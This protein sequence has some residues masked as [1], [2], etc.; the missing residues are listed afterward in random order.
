M[1][2]GYNSY[3]GSTRSLVKFYLLSLPS[4]SNIMSANVNAYQTKTDATNASIDAY[5]SSWASSVT[6]NT[7]PAI[8]LMGGLIGQ[9]HAD[10]FGF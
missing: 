8:N 5:T 9:K 1:D 2:T 3:F 10:F 7:Q 4:D 6:W